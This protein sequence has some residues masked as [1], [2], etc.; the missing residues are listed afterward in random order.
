MF[1]KLASL[2]DLFNKP[3]SEIIFNVK[4]I[5]DIGE[6]SK[7]IKNEGLTKVQINIINDNKNMCFK[8]KNKR[9]IDRKSINILRNKDILT[10]I[11]LK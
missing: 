1:K 6:I 9:F 2:K 11:Q 4:S 7:I 10:V 8:L 3:V 5:E